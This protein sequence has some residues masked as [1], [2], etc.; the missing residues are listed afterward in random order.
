MV[1]TCTARS[2]ELLF[3]ARQWTENQCLQ[4]RGAKDLVQS[5]EATQPEKQTELEEV[6]CLHQY[7]VAQSKSSS[8]MAGATV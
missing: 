1:A 3:G 2:H 6:C 7:C 8:S 5:L 4:D